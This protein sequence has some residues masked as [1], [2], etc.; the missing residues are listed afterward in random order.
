M[1]QELLC[2]VLLL[3]VVFVSSC[4]CVKQLI[5][6][7]NKRDKHAIINK[8]VRS[9]FK[10]PETTPIMKKFYRPILSDGTLSSVVYEDRLLWK[11][12]EFS[13]LKNIKGWVVEEKATILL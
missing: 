10:R 11:T 5:S 7:E 2:L 12:K 6:A 8:Q 9:V 1:E 3:S 13:E 4:L